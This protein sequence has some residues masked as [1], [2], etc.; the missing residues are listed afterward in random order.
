MDDRRR[1]AALHASTKELNRTIHVSTTVRMIHA[2]T[3]DRMIRA[4]T[5]ELNGAIRVSMAIHTIRAR[6][7]VSHV[8]TTVSIHACTRVSRARK[9]EAIGLSY[10]E[11]ADTNCASRR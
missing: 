1:W 4:S 11:C 3:K 10:T 8:R 6:T 9:T 2:S 5:K 7:T